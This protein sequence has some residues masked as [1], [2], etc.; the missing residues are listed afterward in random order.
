MTTFN[1]SINIRILTQY[2]ENAIIQQFKGISAVSVGEIVNFLRSLYPDLAQKTIQWRIHELKKKG[3]IHH[4]SRGIYSFEEK[5]AYQPKISPALKRLQSKVRKELPYTAFCVWDSRWFNEFMSLQLFKH[6]LV[7]ETEKESTEAV[8]ARLSGSGLKVFI[9][10]DRSV[11]ENYISNYDEVIIVKSMISEA[12][13]IELDGIACASL[14]KLLVDCLADGL[15][16]SAQ[17][18]ELSSIFENAFNR[19]NVNVNSMKRY[20]SRRN[21]QIDLE[22]QLKTLAKKGNNAAILK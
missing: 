11:Y 12:P 18:N 13:T 3:V 16:F 21:K 8:Y 19:Y 22:K 5:I 14:E 4:I 2:V 6:F 7:I 1:Y 15:M 10:P 17:Q 9:E 20:A